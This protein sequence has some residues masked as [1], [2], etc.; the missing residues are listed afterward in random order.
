LEAAHRQSPRIPPPGPF[1]ALPADDSAASASPPAT[2]YS[3]PSAKPSAIPADVPTPS[4]KNSFPIELLPPNLPFDLVDLE[5]LLDSPTNP[6]P[7]ASSEAP[8]LPLPIPILPTPA[9]AYEHAYNRVTAILSALP[10]PLHA[11]AM[12]EL[13]DHFTHRVCNDPQFAGFDMQGGVIPP[14]TRRVGSRQRP[15]VSL[16]VKMREVTRQLDAVHGKAKVHNRALRDARKKLK[17]GSG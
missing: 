7:S 13:T 17:D 1:A 6:I 16:P 12:R 8:D 9:T 3:A 10:L 2:K 15:P 5:S 11:D 4:A 14:P